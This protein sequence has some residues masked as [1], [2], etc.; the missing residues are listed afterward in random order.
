[1]MRKYILFIFV[2]VLTAML[3]GCIV[4]KSPSNY[5]VSMAY[6]EQKVFS[7]KSIPD[8]T[9]TWTLDGLPLPVTGN[10]YTYTALAGGHTLVVRAPH[11]TFGEEV[12]AWYIVANSPPVANAGANQTVG[13]GVTVTMDGSNSSDPDGDIVSYAWTQID[14]PEVTLSDASAMLPTFT[15]P[16]VPIGGAALTFELTV[17]DATGLT[18]TATTIV[19]VTWSN[20]P[21]TAIAGPDQT[22]RELTLTTLDG[23]G[24]TDPDDGIATYAWK[25]IAGPRVVLSDPSAVQPT[26]TTPDVGVAGTSLT[27][28]LTVTDN[29]G[30]K[31]S[32]TVIVNVSW[33]NLPPTA[34]AGPD[35]TVTEGTLVTLDASGSTDIDDGINTYTWAQISGPAVTLSDAGA[36]KPTFTAPDVNIG[37]AVLIFE[38]TVTDKSGLQ[39]TDSVAIT[40]TWVNAPPNANAGPDLIAAKRSK[41]YLNGTG[42]S[43]PDSDGIASYQWVQTAGTTVTLYNANTA[44]AYFIAPKTSGVS[45]TFQLTV[46]DPGGLSTSD[47]CVVTISAKG[48]YTIISGGF[49]FTLAVKEDGSLWA[50]GTNAYGQLGDGTTVNKLIPTRIGADTDWASVAAGNYHSLA[51]K[52]DGTL[53]AWGFNGN[54]QLGLGDTVTRVVPTQVGAE[55]DWAAVD[56]GAEHSVGIKADGT[57]MAWGYNGYGQLGNGSM[58]DAHVPSPVGDGLPGWI[59]I[60][61]GAN[62]TLAIDGSGKLWAWGKNN[63]GQ[64][65]IGTTET[66]YDPV[67]VGTDTT[68]VQ[69]SAGDDQTIAQ[70]AA[71]SLWGF[72][73]NLLG[74][75]GDGTTVSKTSPVQI[76]SAT[77]WALFDTGAAHTAALTTSGT[78]WC[79]GYNAYGQ[80][81]DGSTTNR[82]VPTAIDGSGW[83]VVD[84][85]YFD[86]LAVKID[87]T[88]WTWGYN[89]LGQLGDGTT[90]DKHVPSPIEGSGW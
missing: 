43:D 16:T 25:Q 36:V 58:L 86:T 56:A 84:V 52:K 46:T 47:S 8:G 77:N 64:L 68:W 48:P 82:L 71:G 12:M 45:F 62:H 72:G 89:A 88:L 53:W 10:A 9:F 13:E 63:Y 19:N 78:L 37:D 66:K 33:Q 79:W 74:Q 76:G 80:L 70:K 15:S 57:L 3:G 81:G 20:K 27:F 41:V 85:G 69:V 49:N 29:G 65:G 60:N 83:L 75:L 28:R 61:A 31:A 32:D 40:V 22:V 51:L 35:Q 6:G 55:T 17:T 42:S 18:A 4:S 5:N 44:T 38:V 39:S 73:K 90:V 54:G 59:A 7:V 2:V 26:F 34:N 1:M 23:S 24:S 30:L 87:S 21:P 50:W 14:G 67:Q 11:T